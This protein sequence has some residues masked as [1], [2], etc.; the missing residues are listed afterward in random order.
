MK[1][2]P[3]QESRSRVVSQTERTLRLLRSNNGVTNDTLKR[4]SLRYTAIIQAMRKEGY[5][6]VVENL[7][8]GLCKYYLLSEPET[9]HM[10][11]EPTARELLLDRVIGQGSVTSEE[12]V[13][14]LNDLSLTLMRKQRKGQ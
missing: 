13:N 10:K 5:D 3:F 14:I 11:K 1:Q 7:G 8:E 12:L 9:P 2:T 4:I 6:I